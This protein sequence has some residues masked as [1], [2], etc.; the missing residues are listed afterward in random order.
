[1]RFLFQTIAHSATLPIFGIISCSTFDDPLQSP[2]LLPVPFSF[3]SPLFIVPTNSGHSLFF[4]SPF[5]PTYVTLSSRTAIYFSVAGIFS[6][7]VNVLFL[8]QYCHPPSPFQYSLGR[9]VFSVT[10]VRTIKH[11]HRN[12]VRNRVYIQAIGYL[13]H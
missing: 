5:F 3:Y 10:A 12:K 6:F 7:S 1:M 11:V 9:W 2:L 8:F 4:L 13:K